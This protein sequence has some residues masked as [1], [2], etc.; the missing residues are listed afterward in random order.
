MQVVKHFTVPTYSNKIKLLKI[1]LN[2]LTFYTICKKKKSDKKKWGVKQEHFNE[3]FHTQHK[4]FDS[5]KCCW[6][7]CG[8][9]EC[10]NSNLA[11][12]FTYLL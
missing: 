12:C 7:E 4:N 1:I 3:L 8:L 10:S 2:I 11:T 5:E 9:D 6:R